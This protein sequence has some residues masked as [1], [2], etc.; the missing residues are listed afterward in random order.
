M[1]VTILTESSEESELDE[2]EEELSDTYLL[3]MPII[4][5]QFIYSRTLSIIN[6]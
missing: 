4:I 5:I 1:T 6:Q 3:G 2:L